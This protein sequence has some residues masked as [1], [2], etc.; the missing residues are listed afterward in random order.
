MNARA[1]VSVGRFCGL[2][3]ALARVPAEKAVACRVCGETLRCH[4]PWSRLRTFGFAI[5][6]MLLSYPA[7]CFPLASVDYMGHFN[8]VSMLEAIGRLMQARHFVMG[9][10]VALTAVLAPVLQA[11][12]WC[13][14]AV[15]VKYPRWTT[16]SR[17]SHKIVAGMKPWDMTP[18]FLVAHCVGI[19]K[20]GLA[21]NVQV[22]SGAYAFTLMVA[23]IKCALV[24]FDAASTWEERLQ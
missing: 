2:I 10:F 23:A 17:C 5:G 4:K 13:L 6:A 16:V 1:A 3:Q 7:I 21:G 8:E 15:S 22:G 9:S 18:L 11:A 19:L 20:F 12:G 14:L 24:T